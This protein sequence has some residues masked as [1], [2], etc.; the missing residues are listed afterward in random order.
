MSINT[1]VAMAKKRKS[2]SKPEKRK[3]T[4]KLAS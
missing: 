4:Q 1:K 3:W 2:G